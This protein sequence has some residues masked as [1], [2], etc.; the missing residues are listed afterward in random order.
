MVASM[1]IQY[2]FRI[3]NFPIISSPNVLFDYTKGFP[4]N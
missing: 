4:N 2:Q 3:D 1:V